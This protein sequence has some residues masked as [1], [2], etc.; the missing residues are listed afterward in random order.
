MIASF[1]VTAHDYFITEQAVND[2]YIHIRREMRLRPYI[3]MKQPAPQNSCMGMDVVLVVKFKGHIARGYKWKL[4]KNDLIIQNGI[5]DHNGMAYGLN[6]GF[7]N[8]VCQCRPQWFRTTIRQSKKPF[9]INSRC[10]A[11][12][13]PTYALEFDE[14]DQSPGLNAVVSPELSVTFE[15]VLTASVPSESENARETQKTHK[16]VIA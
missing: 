8:G 11:A 1:I 12:V 6:I 14:P 3:G 10:C 4:I 16:E 5:T 15:D 7:S 2:L 13:L 9:D